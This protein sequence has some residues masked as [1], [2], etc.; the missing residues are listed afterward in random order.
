MA[1]TLLVTST[2]KS[3]S[4]I[5]PIAGDNHVNAA[6]A[7][8]PVTVRGTS[9]GFAAGTVISVRLSGKLTTWTGIIDA[10]GNW[11]V[12]IPDLNDFRDGAYTLKV[13]V[14]T[15][16]NAVSTTTS[17]VIDKTPPAMVSL[18]A[19]PS[20]SI[21][22]VGD[23][24]VFRLQLSEGVAVTGSPTL[25]LND[26]GVATYVS[27]SRSRWL[28][29]RYTVQQGQNTNDL[30]AVALSFNG[31]S[32]V[33]SNGNRVDITK[34]PPDIAGSPV[35]D[36]AAPVVQSVTTSSLSA[37]ATGQT[38]DF[39]VTMSESV[40]VAGTPSLTLNDGGTAVY[41]SGSGTNQLVFRH[42]VEVGQKSTDLSVTG[43]DMNDASI[44]DAAGNAA[45]MSGVV[46][47]PDGILTENLAQPASTPPAPETT[48]TI[49]GTSGDDVLTV[50]PDI[51]SV[52]G[53][54]G[55]DTASFTW[56]SVEG[57][58]I[59]RLQDG[60][61][62]VQDQTTGSTSIHLSQIETISFPDGTAYDVASGAA[63]SPNTTPAAV[64]SPYLIGTSL[65]DTFKVSSSTQFVIGAGGTDTAILTWGAHDWFQFSTPL[66]GRFTA[67]DVH[68]TGAVITFDSI[69]R[70][71]FADGVTYGVVNG[72]V[73][74][75][76]TSSPGTST[77]S[78]T[79]SGS[80]TTTSSTP[81]SS[82]VMT[83]PGTD[84][85]M[86][87]TLQNT[88]TSALSAHEITFGM[89]F[90]QGQVA[91]GRQL[92]ATVN[93]QTVPVQMDVK[94]TFADGSARTAVLTM[95]QPAL[96]AVS[97]AEVRFSATTASAPAALDLTAALSKGYDVSVT[98][99]MAGGSAQKF[100]VGALL[101]QALANGSASYWLHG[102]QATQARFSVPV[103]GSFR[104]TFDVTAFQDGTFKTDA[105]FN[106][107]LAMQA[108]GGPVTYDVTISQNGQTAFSQSGLSQVQYQT[109]HHVLWSNGAP[110]VNIQQD[111]RALENTGAILPYDLSTGVSQTIFNAQA[112]TMTA[113][114]WGD[115]LSPNGV[116]QNMPM[117]GGRA[118]I[119]PTTVANTVWLMT[120]DQRAAQ[121]AL[122][123]ADAAGAVP[124]HFFDP[125][126]GQY[127][128]VTQY[129]TLWTDPRGGTGAPG[130]LTQQV[131]PTKASGW[132]PDSAH[133]P[134]LSYVAHLMTGDRYY[135]DQLN[136]QASYS[137]MSVW[138]YWRHD[139]LGLVAN[140]ENQVRGQAW[141]LREVDD[142]A[143]ANPDGS[144]EKAYFTQ[145][146]NN[147]WS[148]LVSQIPVW[149]AQQGEAHG[150]I[151]GSYGNYGA[152]APW[153]QDF[154]VSTT[155]HAALMGNQDAATFLKWQEN[156]IVGRFLNAAKGFNPH[157][158]VAYNLMVFD[159]T[160]GTPFTTW[161]QIEQA[162]LAAGLSN[163]TGWSRITGLEPQAALQSLA[164]IITVNGS[165]QA[166]KAYGWLMASGAP[167]IA[168]SDMQN[169]GVAFNISPRLPDG[170]YLT[171][172]HIHITS[173]TIA[174]IVKGE[175]TASQL[176]YETG[177]GAVTLVGG[178]GTNLMFA[179][180]GGNT[181]QGGANAD[182]LFGGAGN[183]IFMAGAGKNFMQTDGGADTIVLSAKDLAQDLIDS[184]RIGT[185]H[186][187][188]LDGSGA[189][190]SSAAL[191][192]L[193]AGATSNSSGAAVLHIAPG[194]DTTL[195]GI[196]VSQL[197][198][199]LF[200]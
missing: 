164:G 169:G 43:L 184:F 68:D 158:G 149:T 119:G 54:D 140:G 34:V 61:V 191:Q 142:A 38:V 15:G 154:F 2:S 88:H 27:G 20:D 144:P 160:T 187:H 80:G 36:T 108:V 115:P 33:D 57:F 90:Q 21:L 64:E 35:V 130:G 189:A 124:W 8:G 200:N 106:N 23:Q 195:S 78:G 152:T 39:V 141:S 123:Q 82:L 85:G 70:L 49:V 67:T 75:S 193:I 126:T 11:R 48:S 145:I 46:V 107:D 94:T 63:S 136:A 87:V 77:G 109:W 137:I 131:D 121:Y 50:T 81:S 173:D 7:A 161:A 111:V 170:S 93:G 98:L 69:E 176:L 159:S 190:L 199:N 177:T 180:S 182:Y 186:L 18:S 172:D 155:V 10:N 29:F 95:M 178:S 97:S 174:G 179:G 41:V 103:S 166:M 194:H 16:R 31:G 185:D 196:G 183:D 104:L 167:H 91:A 89:V 101:R 12:D 40:Q 118:D 25:Q 181:L 135:L 3:L 147:N 83:P 116:T 148:Y 66:N 86:R 139:G 134:N 30:S 114:G 96:A 72:V 73:Q 162:S 198:M 151:P 122:G 65:D 125:Q 112:N 55:T 28:T 163:G 42:T 59:T 44:V 105:Q 165:T 32:I 110:Q 157:D 188:V 132:S 143:F 47:N 76:T 146:S 102:A 51:T 117:T 171:R 37:L 60:S 52:V 150:W 13:F 153:Q 192:Q 92:V 84:T 17:L 120:Q 168:T 1:T 129:P 26:G 128:G 14:G 99:T 113:A 45:A 56:G 156:F 62:T 100:D 9:T 127:L 4:V 74:T 71:Q 133:Q 175:A 53:G 24:V 197:G 22:G 79:S 5:G 6:E 138:N 58:T 19:T